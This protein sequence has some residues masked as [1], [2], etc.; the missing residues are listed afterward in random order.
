MKQRSKFLAVLLLLFTLAPLAA[1]KA[2]AK[3]KKP[4]PVKVVD[5][6]TED[7]T[8]EEKPA[9]KDAVKPPQ[10]QVEK[11]VHDR[12]AAEFEKKAPA[13]ENKPSEKTETPP[14][15]TAVFVPPPDTD[16][17]AKK[18]YI[19]GGLI[20]TNTY[21]MDPTI[22]PG[23]Y[24]GFF[25]PFAK[26]TYDEKWE[27]SARGLMT[28]K[29][30]IEPLGTLKQTNVVG[31]LEIL[32]G[33][34][35]FGTHHIMAGRNFYAIEQGLLFANF[36]DGVSYTGKYAFGSV[37][38]FAV[39]S[40]DY[41]SSLCGLNV[42][43]CNGDPSPF[44]NTPNLAPDAGIQNSGKRVFFAGEYFSP[45][46]LGGQL[47]AYTLISRDLIKE[48]GVNA[49]YEYNPW[50]GGAGLRGYVFNSN[51]RYRGD[52]IYQ[53][54]S[55]YNRVLNGSSEQTSI[56]AMAM[57]AN[58]TWT[59]PMMKKI[60]PQLTADFAMGTGDAD[61]S[62]VNN[63]SQSN[64][65]GSY[66]AFQ[67]FG[68]FSGGLALKPRLANLQVYRLGTYFR[69]FKSTYSLRNLSVQLKYSYYRKSVSVGGI[70][71]PYATEDDANVG[72][73]ADLALVYNV[74]ADVQFFYGFG[75]FKPGAAYPVLNFDGTDGQ[76]WRYAHLVSLTLIF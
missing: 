75:L 44:V 64:T 28:V 47:F 20:A 74:K 18:H 16:E 53:G 43:G 65:S 8:Y 23:L 3:K 38:A 57:L 70:S 66:T 21:Y 31:S 40:G 63:G 45:E 5:E 34:T 27:F 55:T 49:K 58:F 10:S 41:G 50:Y 9:V 6:D 76:A 42:T 67:N 11:S 60:D 26:Y 29:H 4:V 39:F 61:S 33:E 19:R 62:R 32:A 2:K 15:A 71:D 12:E 73:A 36:A 69:P 35:K 30:Y 7:E 68:S 13:A 22:N 1:Q 48:D 72:H 17:V 54:G 25:R 52:F 24:S 37:R 14:V 51:Y 56:S 59:L 46:Y